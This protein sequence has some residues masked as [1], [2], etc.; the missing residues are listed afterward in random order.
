LAD[1]D[2]I[3]TA[4]ELIQAKTGIAIRSGTHGLPN[5]RPKPDERLKVAARKSQQ[6]LYVGCASEVF[7]SQLHWQRLPRRLRLGWR[8][9]ETPPYSVN[10]DRDTH[11]L[12]PVAY[13]KRDL[14]NT[15][16]PRQTERCRQV[17]CIRC[18]Y[19]VQPI[20]CRCYLDVLIMFEGDKDLVG[21]THFDGFQSWNVSKIQT[22]EELVIV[23]IEPNKVPTAPV[24][25][26]IVWNS[27]S[28]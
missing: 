2:R 3:E 7:G 8:T 17:V 14:S 22:I 1:L 9:P 16:V 6:Q 19:Q 12:V 28:A 5:V 4:T 23:I 15:R 27:P 24:W 25:Q 10:V 18:G 26:H 21:L 13:L 11:R 20:A